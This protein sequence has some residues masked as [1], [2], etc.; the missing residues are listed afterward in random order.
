ML[1]TSQKEQ[2][3]KFEI[4]VPIISAENPTAICSFNY[5]QEHFGEVFDIRTADGER[6]P[7]RLPRLRPRAR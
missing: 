5:H 3:L 4:L 1:A 7:H 2:N 6:R